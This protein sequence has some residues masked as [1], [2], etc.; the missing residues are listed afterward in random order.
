VPASRPGV[1]KRAEI[2]DSSLRA[3]SWIRYTITLRNQGGQSAR[4]VLVTDTIDPLTILDSASIQISC[5]TTCSNAVG[6]AQECAL[7]PTGNASTVSVVL[8]EVRA[9]ATCTITFKVQVRSSVKCEDVIVNRAR[10]QYDARDLWT[11]E[12]RLTSQCRPPDL[13]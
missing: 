10:I 3:G 2:L 1:D 12:T 8:P 13:V 5:N 11:N 7:P 9:G 6:E 4:N